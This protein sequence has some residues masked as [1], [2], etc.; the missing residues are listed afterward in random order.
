MSFVFCFVPVVGDYEHNENGREKE[1]CRETKD[2]P[3]DFVESDGE[4]SGDSQHE[5]KEH[6]FVRE[7]EQETIFHFCL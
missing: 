4:D 3:D 1:N 5:P 7:H 6:E 2:D